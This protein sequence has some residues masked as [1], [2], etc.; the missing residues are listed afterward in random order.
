MLAFLHHNLDKVI[1]IKSFIID[2]ALDNYITNEY[3]LHD[4]HLDFHY[5]TLSEY[6]IN[7]LIDYNPMI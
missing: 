3:C 2:V 5:R 1:S 7:T 6:N 4:R